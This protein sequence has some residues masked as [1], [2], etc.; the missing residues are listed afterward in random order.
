MKTT[1]DEEKAE[2]FNKYFKEVFTKE[3]EENIPDVPPKEVESILREIII[4]EVDVL[5]KLKSMNPNKSA[6]PDQIP[7]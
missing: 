3:D 4:T 6:G 7:P 2:V 1:S 5:K